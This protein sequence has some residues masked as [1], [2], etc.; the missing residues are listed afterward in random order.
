MAGSEAAFDW[1]VVG[2]GTG[3][4]T[5]AARAAGKLGTIGLIEAGAEAPPPASRRPADYVRLFGSS[6]DWAHQTLPQSNLAGRVIP[7]PRGRMVGGSSGIN[8]MIHVPPLAEDLRRWS[9]CVS[10]WSESSW[11][12]SSRWL[13]THW[14]P[15]IGGGH[16]S[17]ITR[18]AVEAG[19]RCGYPVEIYRRTIRFG[20]RRTPASLMDAG[21]DRIKALAGLTA[22]SVRIGDRGAESVLCRTA[23]GSMQSISARRGIVLAAGTLGTPVLLWNSGIGPADR[24][25]EGG[26]DTV[27]DQPAIGQNLQDHVVYPVIFATGRRERFP[28]TFSPLD[29]L[30]WRLLGSGPPASN[31]AEAGGFVVGDAPGTADD[32]I[33]LHLTPTHYLVHPHAQ[34]PAAVSLAVTPSRPRSAGALHPQPVGDG[35]LGAAIDPNYLA[36][37]HDRETILRG[38]EVARRIARTEPL[39]KHVTGELVP[40]E[41]ASHRRVERSIERYTQTLYHPVG[42]CRAGN[43]QHSVVSGD[44]RVR[45]IDKLFV[46]D[47]SVLPDV[48]T[49][50]PHATVMLVAA[51][52][53]ERLVG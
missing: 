15:S 26:I 25:R 39:S 49:G 2:A 50:N 51:R 9:R 5:F 45:G 42:T 3:G 30:R 27:L 31:L 34:A 35:R 4:C 52:L 37:P 14:E 6:C 36:D 19:R 38:I 23:S 10:D 33:Q 44:F 1:V 8:A 7:W 21:R 53:A 20:R 46:A 40:G 16:T 13:Q 47:A 32:L 12:D 43:D 29:R 17:E 48:T 24:L 11:A 18:L 22:Q 28:T 41:N